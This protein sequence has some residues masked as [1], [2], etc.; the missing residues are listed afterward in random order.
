[1][2]ISSSRQHGL[3]GANRIQISEIAAYTQLV[4]CPIP[5]RWLLTA[6]QAI[7]AEYMK[8]QPKPKQ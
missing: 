8:W 1:M 7:D 6:I 3:G 5:H 2:T 4:E